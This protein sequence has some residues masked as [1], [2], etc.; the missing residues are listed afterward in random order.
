MNKEHF[1]KWLDDSYTDT[2]LINEVKNKYN[3]NEEYISIPTSSTGKDTELL[4]SVRKDLMLGHSS[5]FIETGTEF[6]GF[7]LQFTDIK[8]LGL[9]TC[10]LDEPSFIISK[11]RFQ[12]FD[13]KSYLKMSKPF[14]EGLQLKDSDVFFLDAHGGGY[15][16]INDNPLTH[17]L[18][19]IENQKIKPIIYIHDFG[20]EYKETDPPITSHLWEHE[21]LEKKYWYRFDFT[22]SG[23]KLDWDFIKDN[24]ERIYGK[25]GYDITY[26]SFDEPEKHPVGWVKISSK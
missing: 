5:R 10:E 21:N 25:D 3:Q 1:F 26:P 9:L 8:G 2:N 13:I 20:I 19:E 23:W 4:N 17:E 11:Y 15:D 22:G 6:G 7:I 14:L 18:I 24:I 16:E 12:N